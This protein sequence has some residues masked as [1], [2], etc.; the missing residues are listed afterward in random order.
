MGGSSHFFDT[1]LASTWKDWGETMKTPVKIQTGQP[2]NGSHVVCYSAKLSWYIKYFKC[3]HT[4]THY[5]S[6]MSE[7]NTTQNYFK[8]IHY[9]S[10]MLESNNSHS[11]A[12]YCIVTLSFFCK[13]LL[14]VTQNGCINSGDSSTTN[15]KKLRQ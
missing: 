13:D 3:I 14:L 7:S 4:Y 12:E 2:L 8:Y 1:L 15:K 9:I 5:T 11:T 6:R 10:R